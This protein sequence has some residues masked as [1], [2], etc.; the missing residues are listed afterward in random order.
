M[1][2][3]PG[4]FPLICATCDLRIP[5]GS[6]V[7]DGKVSNYS[8]IIVMFGITQVTLEPIC[9]S[10]LGFTY[11]FVIANIVFQ[12]INQITDLKFSKSYGIVGP[13]VTI[14]YGYCPEYSTTVLARIGPHANFL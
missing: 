13:I 2:V 10:I 8:G 3:D 9:D 1:P 4:Q 7:T 6:T 5:L 11:M 12:A 14:H